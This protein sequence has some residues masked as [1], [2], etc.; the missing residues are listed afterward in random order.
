MKILIA[1]LIA[2]SAGLYAVTAAPT[3]Q[4]SSTPRSNQRDAEEGFVPG[5][6]G[7]VFAAG[8][9]EGA[10]RAAGLDFEIEGRVTEILVTEG[11]KV[12]AGDVLA[13]LD[14]RMAKEQ[15]AEAEA[16]LSL[17]KAEQDRLRKGAREETLRVA[18]SEVTLAETSLGYSE[19]V[20]NRAQRLSNGNAI[21]KDDLDNRGFQQ[22]Q[23]MARV[24]VAR[25]RLG[26]LAAP[27]REEDLAVMAARV[28]MAEAAVARARVLLE[29]TELRAPAAATLLTISGE[30]GELVGPG[31]PQPFLTLANTDTL[32]VRAYIEELDALS[33]E[34]GQTA[35]ASADARPGTCYQGCVV[36]IAPS[37]TEKSLRHGQPGERSDVRVREVL[38]RL[39][40]PRDL[41]I[42][43]PVDV[44]LGPAPSGSET[45]QLDRLAR[46][47]EPAPSQVAE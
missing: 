14:N 33:L 15:L 36:W 34:K 24:E 45:G 39:D 28:Q 26:E 31:R 41:V 40:A 29:K 11:S 6:G 25:S 32:H 30:T 1:A 46:V 44:F 42:G 17:A 35:V 3:G 18:R 2:S 38:I 8:L 12:Q 43:L 23:A 22:K 16:Q 4:P 19:S 5:F 7:K 27:A 21:S 37:M 47:A 20:W 10:D 13:R 9:V